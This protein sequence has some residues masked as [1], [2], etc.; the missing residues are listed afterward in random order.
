MF[1]LTDPHKLILIAACCLCSYCPRLGL[2]YSISVLFLGISSVVL[3]L[4]QLSKH[5]LLYS[6]LLNYI[7]S[8]SYIYKDDS[9]WASCSWMSIK[10]RTCWLRLKCKQM[11][12]RSLCWCLSPIFPRVFIQTSEMHPNC[13]TMTPVFMC[14]SS[15]FTFYILPWQRSSF[16]LEKSPGSPM[17]QQN[18][19]TCT[20]DIIYYTL[21]NVCFSTIGKGKYKMVLNILLLLL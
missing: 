1:H 14:I 2:S 5:D 7:V 18:L 9:G 17:I 21:S 19:C 8:L 10:M 16:W 15:E 6:V 20:I 11:M 4:C 13:C 3:Y 12:R